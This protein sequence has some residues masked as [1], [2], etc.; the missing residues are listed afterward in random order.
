MTPAIRRRAFLAAAA[1]VGG[2]LVWGMS[3]LPPAGT[4]R[5]PYGLVLNQV[6]VAERHTTNVVAAVTFDYRG[7]D[8]MGEEF[9][10]FSAVI[11]VAILLRAI[12]GEA[13]HEP[14]EAARGRQ[15]PGTSD[16]VRVGG[17]TL[18]GPIVLFGVYM[19]THGHLS[20][21]GGFQGGVVLATGALLVYLSGEYV[22]LRRVR[23]ESTLDSGEAVGAGGYVVVGLFGLIAGGAFLGNALPHGTAGT[24]LSGGTVPVINLAVGLEVAAGFTLLLSEFLEQTLVLGPEGPGRGGR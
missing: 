1:V 3:G 5:G 23:P 2:L 15:V 19:V 11:G 16:A 21:G 13:E 12:R 18:L 9:I 10:L 4:Y 17:L 22:T 20:P 24:L 8:T 6:A 7:A 14:E